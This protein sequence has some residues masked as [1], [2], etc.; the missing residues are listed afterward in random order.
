MFSFEGF[1]PARNLPTSLGT[2]YC[3]QFSVSVGRYFTWCHQPFYPCSPPDLGSFLANKNT[4]LLGG[5][6]RRVLTTK[7]TVNLADL[8]LVLLVLSFGCLGEAPHPLATAVVPFFFSEKSWEH[9]E[10]LLE[11]CCLAGPIAGATFH[12]T[13]L[14]SHPRSTRQGRQRG[15]GIW[16]TL[17]MLNGR[18]SRTHD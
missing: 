3:F 6:D 9:M 12:Q 7:R 17:R 11:P 16:Q 18:S 4:F 15:Q 8:A 1:C 13:L 10:R 2:V 5:Q 14:P